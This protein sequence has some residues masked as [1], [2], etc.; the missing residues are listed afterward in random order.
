MNK[1]AS[2]I[3]EKLSTSHYDLSQQGGRKQLSDSEFEDKFYKLDT[4]NDNSIFHLFYNYILT[5]EQ[6]DLLI[7]GLDENDIDTLGADDY[8]ID[9]QFQPLITDEQR[10]EI[11]NIINKNYNNYSK[12]DNEGI[13]ERLKSNPPIV[14]G[15]VK[16]YVKATMFGR[17]GEQD[18]SYYLINLA[19][20]YSAAVAATVGDFFNEGDIN[21]ANESLL[22][23]FTDE[24]PTISKVNKIC[25]EMF[26]DMKKVGNGW[27]FDRE[28]ECIGVGLT[29]ADANQA[30]KS[31]YAN[32]DAD[33]EDDD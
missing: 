7:N 4:D 23:Y 25:K 26:D 30:W 2:S 6:A 16:W 18:H 28:E 3:L 17:F 24:K 15:N 29:K 21:K 14:L 19:E 8:V 9:K 20:G 11:T 31:V 5:P 10:K 12:Q 27:A 13:Q 22:E 1:F 33:W 32:D